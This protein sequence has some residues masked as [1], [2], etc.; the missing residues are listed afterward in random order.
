M[1]VTLKGERD[2]PMTKSQRHDMG[3]HAS[4]EEESCVGMP[5]VVESHRREFS[6]E[7]ID[8][9]VRLEAG[10][11]SACL[12]IPVESRGWAAIQ[13][14]LEV[15]NVSGNGGRYCLWERRKSTCASQEIVDD[16]ESGWQHVSFYTPLTDHT[17]DSELYLY[18]DGD[19]VG[20]PTVVEY[21]NI[22]VTPAAGLTIT[23]LATD[24]SS[25]PVVGTTSRQASPSHAEV[26]ID[27]PAAA[28]AV[29]VLDDSF[30]PRWRLEVEG[31]DQ[32]TTTHVTVDGWKN[33]WALAE[34]LPAG[35][36][37]VLTYSMEPWYD[38]AR[39]VSAAAAMSALIGALWA[40]V[41]RSR[42]AGG[43]SPGLWE[44]RGIRSQGQ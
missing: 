15:R 44:G 23:A 12:R 10:D 17:S 21:R 36:T 25:Q 26:T 13:V 7:R 24:N 22:S 2:A 1:R 18:A 32:P 3:W 42:R 41:R 19:G 37:L 6:G 20:E 16:S 31:V 27:G 9:G 34:P 43:S 14:D 11:H 38:L 4:Q 5:H 30:D 35:A 28:G 8:G 33:G 40:A 39:I 29:V